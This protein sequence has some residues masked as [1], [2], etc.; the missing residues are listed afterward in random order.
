VISGGLES[1]GGDRGRGLFA[2]E[3]SLEVWGGGGGGAS[4]SSCDIDACR[5]RLFIESFTGVAP[6]SGSEV[7]RQ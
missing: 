1:R 4:G 7:S 6:G 2:L 3:K 5:D